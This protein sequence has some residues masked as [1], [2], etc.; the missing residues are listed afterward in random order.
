MDVQFEWQKIS[1]TK[2]NTNLNNG[3]NS[4]LRPYA[5]F[6]EIFGLEFYLETLII[7]DIEIP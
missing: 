1:L 4:I 3:S 5:T 2:W 6:K 7:Y